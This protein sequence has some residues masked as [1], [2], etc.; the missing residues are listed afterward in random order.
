MVRPAG[1]RS[2]I[3]QSDG[4]TITVQKCLERHSLGVMLYSFLNILEK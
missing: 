3:E 2:I 4:I 1:A